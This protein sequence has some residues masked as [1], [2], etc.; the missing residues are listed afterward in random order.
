M[1]ISDD[2][3][4]VTDAVSEMYGNF[5]DPADIRRQQFRPLSF[6]S[7]PF[8]ETLETSRQIASPTSPRSP[9]LRL[10]SNE[11]TTSNLTSK[12]LPPT[13]GR[14]TS[15]E[16]TYG[17]PSPE[18]RSP[19]PP[20][21][22]SPSETATQQFPLND[23]DYES[24]PAAVA[25]EL[26]NLQAIRRM[27]MDVSGMD[28]DLPTFNSTMS[29]PT[30]AP[31]R[32]SEEDDPNRLFWVPARLHP[33]LA[34]KEFKSFISDR[35]KTIKR[36]SLSGDSLST[37]ASDK[38]RRRKS[39][40][41]RQVNDGAGYQ[42]GAERLERKKSQSGSEVL[43]GPA[44]HL[45]D[46]EALVDD[47]TNMMKTMSENTARRSLESTSQ[48]EV[49]AS[50]DLPILGP[51]PPGATLKRSTRTQYRRGSLKKGDRTAPLRRQ[52]MKGEGAGSEDVIS[53]SS[54]VS[55]DV[56]QLPEIPGIYSAGLGRVNSAPNPTRSG[57]ENFSRP[58]RRGPS[59][60]PGSDGADSRQEDPFEPI[61]HQTSAPAQYPPRSA[62]TS[63]TS[64]RP[65]VPV[66]V[67]TIVETPPEQPRTKSPVSTLQQTAERPQQTNSRPPPSQAPQQPLP[68]RPSPRP[69]LSRGASLPQ[70]GAQPPAPSDDM[71]SRLH[72]NQRTD[73]LS[74]VPVIVEDKKSEKDKKGKDK[75]E[76][77]KKGG[78]NWFSSKGDDDKDKDKEDKKNKSKLSK[79]AE[80]DRSHD[81]ARLDVLQASIDGP[82]SRESLVLD[83]RNI[84]IED[85]SP[86]KAPRKVS[87]E[88]KEKDG[89][90]SSL[91]GGSKKKGEKDASNKKGL[92]AHRGLSPDPPPRILRPD[93]DYNWSR[94][95]ILE[96]RAI[97]RMAHLKLANP[98]REL[99]SQVLLSNFM[100][101]Y[102]AKVQ[103]MHP[104]LQ[105][106]QSAAQ[107]REM[108]EKRKQQEAEKKKEM[109]RQQAMQQ[110]QSQ[111]EEFANYQRYQEVSST[112]S[113][114]RRVS[115][116]M[117]SPQ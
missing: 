115:F 66:T 32:N 13:L 49:P 99:Y 100:Y 21:H 90:F 117:L 25:Q 34:P 103:Q 78:W 18:L 41:S 116:Y 96:E 50:E 48:G 7:A 10:P 105:V 15:N 35:V 5:E 108:E 88:K 89:I 106:P 61:S 19:P 31:S 58:G 69:S 87:G 97:Y 84:Q 2:N 53:D 63:K 62:S 91:F 11:R 57:V 77:T 4:H 8:G 107:K 73:N 86:T 82:Q 110:Q 20:L 111:F 68:H 3:H 27:S 28:P 1:S 92:H 12:P 98:R 43:D 29:V 109:E 22:R 51:K 36:S 26:S 83:R 76:E 104:Q 23:I 59:N 102:L 101:S 64:V 42:D 93:V 85:D 14:T 70:R 55:D 45:Q 30:V 44:V 6:V 52:M 37:E 112:L 95:S 24:S 9:L 71:S 39:M 94:F 56:P 74:I 80:K 79:A 81:N 72:G 75:K 60:E 113:T 47:P 54:P 65:N 17:S 114:I 46:L 33:E 16:N 38:L 40:L 67:P